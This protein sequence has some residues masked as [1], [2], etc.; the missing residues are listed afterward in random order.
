MDASVTVTGQSAD[1]AEFRRGWQV[2]LAS[3]LGIGLGLSPMPFYTMGVFAPHLVREFGWSIGQIMGGL[4]VTTLM[5]LW[6]APV[7]GML[8]AR[9]GV[10]RVALGSMLL[11]GLAFM[12]LGLSTGSLTQYYVTWAAVAVLGAGTLPITFTKAVNHW[13][14]R[15]KGLALGL[16]LMGTGLFGMVSKPFLAWVIGEHGWRAGYFALGL[17]PILIALP[18]GF[19]LF[20]DTDTH[21]DAVVRTTTPGGLTLRQTLREWRFW[22][23]AIALVPISFA[24]GGPVPNLETMLKEGG[25]NPGSVVALTPLIG[26]TALIGRLAGGWL[27]DRFWAPAVAFVILSL[28]ALSCWLLT[29]TALDVGTAALSLCL[30]G[31]ALGVEYD[32]VAYFVARYFGLRSYSAIYGVLYVFFSLGS[33]IGPLAFGWDHDRHGSYHGALTLSLVM[34]LVAASSLLLMGRYRVFPDE[35]IVP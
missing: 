1:Y 28:P 24:L 2:V 23:L 22:L 14:D 19:L 15:R 18:T 9:I 7:V 4:T 25:V 34:L 12:T 16:S 13:F 35:R 5:V 11:F 8:A 17:L 27:L 32:V 29:G 26:L 30:I 31:F 21:A 6:A 20:H 3:L 10:R 33:G